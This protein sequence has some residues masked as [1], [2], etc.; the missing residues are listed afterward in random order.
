MACYD[1]EPEGYERDYRYKKFEHNSELAEIACELMQ[2]I[3]R[4]NKLFL[5]ENK[6]ILHLPSQKAMTW[7]NQHKKRD[8]D[9]K[10]KEDAERAEKL[11]KNNA[12]AK[13]TD[14]EKRILR[15]K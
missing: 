11:L 13:L 6:G 12:L 1:P 4:Q 10:L 7:W 14:E 2:A 5:T 9:K 15:L 3:E 8:T